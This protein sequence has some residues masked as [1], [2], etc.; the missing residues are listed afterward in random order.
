[1][2][3]VSQ[4]SLKKYK[5]FSYSSSFRIF[6]LYLFDLTYTFKSNFLPYCPTNSA[7]FKHF[8]RGFSILLTLR[9]LKCFNEQIN[10]SLEVSLKFEEHIQNWA[11]NF[12]LSYIHFSISFCF[13]VIFVYLVAVNF[14]KDGR[15]HWLFSQKIFIID[16]WQGHT[17][18]SSVPPFLL[19]F[20]LL[21]ASLYCSFALHFQ[22]FVL[23]TVKWSC[24]K[25]ILS[26][27]SGQSPE[28]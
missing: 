2:I 24:I 26:N 1:M 22:L 13:N 27:C 15:G 25:I 16:M 10:F 28:E 3:W 6:F 19:W 18:F 17:L 11:W 12:F 23:A 21:E 4:I 8:G 7:L 14:L 5:G 20:F 9:C